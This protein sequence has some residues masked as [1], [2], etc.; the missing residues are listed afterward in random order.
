MRLPS[1]A[2]QA[3]HS[4]TRDTVSIP[5]CTPWHGAPWH[6]IYPTLLVARCG[7]V[8]CGVLWCGVVCCGV[9]WCGVVCCGVARCGVVCC[10]VLWCG[11]VWCGVV[12]WGVFRLATRRPIRFFWISHAMTSGTEGKHWCPPPFLQEC[13]ASLLHSSPFSDLATTEGS[14]MLT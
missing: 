3:T 13:D 8:C 14:T 7:V 6:G 2:R 9:L 1:A 10:G 12:W 11:V 5:C 4:A